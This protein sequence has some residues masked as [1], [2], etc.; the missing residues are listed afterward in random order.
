MKYRYVLYR[1][2]SIS[3]SIYVLHDIKK[4]NILNQT[5]KTKQLHIINNNKKKTNAA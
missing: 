2:Q 3:V 4:I 5:V 1:T